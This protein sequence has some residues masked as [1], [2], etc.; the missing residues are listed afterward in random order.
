MDRVRALNYAR[1][2]ATEMQIEGNAP[3]LEAFGLYPTEDVDEIYIVHDLDE[4]ILALA[5]EIEPYEEEEAFTKEF[6]ERY[7]DT[8][9][10]LDQHGIWYA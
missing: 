1:M 9:D 8:A 5:D 6:N 2:V 3:I 4:V 7:I 10:W